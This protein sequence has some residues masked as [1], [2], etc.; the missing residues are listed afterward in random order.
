MSEFHRTFHL[1][2]SANSYEIFIAQLRRLAGEGIFSHQI[3]V[4]PPQQAIPDRFFDVILRT[5]SRAVRLRIRRDNLYLIGYRQAY[6]D[7]EEDRDRDEAQDRWFEVR[8][9]GNDHL[10]TGSTF[11]ETDG[12]YVS[13]ERI[14]GQRREDINLSQ[15]R[16]QS[17]VETLSRTTARGEIA[18]SL[19]VIIQMI[20]ESMRYVSIS[21]EIARYY[22]EGFFPT[23]QIL[24]YENC[25]CQLCTE[26]L[27]HD[28]DSS[29][30]RI[31]STTGLHRVA[32]AIL[33]L[34][35]LVRRHADRNPR[36]RRDVGMETVGQVPIVAG[37]PLLEVFFVR[38]LNIDGEDP[39]QLYG[40]VTA[41]D[42]AQS[43]Y[44]YNRD[45]ANYETI[46]PDQSV[47]LT[48]PSRAVSAADNFVIEF[49]LMN[50]HS[51]SPDD[52]VSS[53]MIQWNVY[54]HT[55]RYDEILNSTISGDHGSAMLSYVVMNNAA[56]A[57]VE[58]ILINGDGANPAH[59]YGSID[60]QNSSFDQKIDLF[61]RS[62]ND[63]VDVRP[64][65][66]IS[67]LRTN[68]AVP[69]DATVTIGACLW[70]HDAL[71]SEIE[72]AKGTAEFR[73]VISTSAREFI[74]GRY[75]K[76][77]VRVSWS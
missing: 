5:E 45:R 17:A 6:G 26:V 43:Y 7:R 22:S 41:T 59:V 62:E 11:L 24:A 8:N 69:M 61:S 30:F 71:S 75:G 12:S 2:S 36:P 74:E 60:F 51:L 76:I 46:K 55:K 72:I 40:T 34:G 15:A 52:E 48:G 27:S 23:P 58:I 67:L 68:M 64:G 33:V 63:S 3:P 4:L 19:I 65:D 25:W 39:G 47:T 21:N 66:H 29:L 32:E 57:A 28:D 42:C 38:I 35:I 44:I 53:G 16:L 13:L 54:D 49:N 70:H 73:P 9:E 1:S 37:Q 50:R 10:I 77:E 18:A 14:A 56:E 20:C 31:A